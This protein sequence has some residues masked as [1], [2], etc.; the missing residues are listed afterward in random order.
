M[1]KNQL[2]KSLMAVVL[3]LLAGFL[4]MLAMGF[5]PIDGYTSV[6]YTHLALLFS[7][8]PWNNKAIENF[9]D[10]DE[11]EMKEEVV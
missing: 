3:G 10:E 1:H 7:R 4:L 8:R 9:K 5:N 11:E 2:L 6:S